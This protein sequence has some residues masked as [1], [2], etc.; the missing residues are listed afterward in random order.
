M[1]DIIGWAFIIMVI[2]FLLGTMYSIANNIVFRSIDDY[3]EN[4]VFEE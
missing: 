4:E 2:V 1:M 3:D